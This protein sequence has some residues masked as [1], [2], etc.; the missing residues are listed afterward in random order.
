M[1]SKRQEA[2][3]RKTAHGPREA[4]R[5]VVHDLESL[6]GRSKQ[7]LLE[8]A[9]GLNIKGVSKLA[10]AELAKRVHAAQSAEPEAE[11]AR[12]A[13]A[14]RAAP[15]P[16]AKA[17]APARAPAPAAKGPAEKP[18]S[19]KAPVE[20][21]P[22]KAPPAKAP[23]AKASP[24]PAASAPPRGAV[25]PQP[26]PVPAPPAMDEVP[27]A[28]ARAVTPEP[29]P[30]GAVPTERPSPAAA[31]R[32][33]LGVPSPARAREE[34]IPWSY[35]IDRVTAMPVDPDTLY[36]YWE[37]T[38]SAIDRA[39]AALGAAGEG[40]WLNLRVFDT[41]GIIFDGGNAHSWFDHGLGRS[42]RQW[43]FRIGK[44]SSSATVEI[45]M[46]APDG[47][48]ARIARSSRVD[49][50][51]V[52]PSAW[53]DPEWMTV[54]AGGETVHAGRGGP[55]RPGDGHAP[56]MGGGAERH[57][58]VPVWVLLE[59]GEGERRFRELF[60]EHWERIEWREG[61]GEGWYELQGRLEWQVGPMVSSWEEGPFH[62]PVQVDPPSRSTWEG[63]AVA[64]TQGGVTR[65]VYG[66]WQVMIRNLHGR[67]EHAVLGRWQIYR[68]WATNGG[69]E[70]VQRLAT[71]IGAG[72]PGGASERVA[73]SAFLWRV[74][75]EERLGGASEVWRLGASEVRLRG[76]SEILLAGASERRLMGASER[77]LMGASEWRLGGASERQLMG[78]SERARRGASEWRLGGASERHLGGASE[79]ALRGASEQR[80]GGGSEERLGGAPGFTG[81]PGPDDGDWNWPPA[82]DSSAP[83]RE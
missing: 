54:L 76:A 13:P 15:G 9:A 29:P 8:L 40:A 70:E 14:G 80:L 71:G 30:G 46:R 2:P 83:G 38:D 32:L 73:A 52:A 57:E 31:A 56:P 81:S 72:A 5:R 78:A 65:V 64:Y 20:K 7:A 59:P 39:R 16:S 36:V 47:G 12:R 82:D 21:A 62:Y 11:P 23:A 53:S 44:P 60:G 4:G 27:T 41:S 6:L 69:I 75:S 50:P 35:G 18:A 49:F 67:A 58:H 74:G 19:A 37:V 63:G 33:D 42:D 55:V 34:H 77:R 24:A 25:E 28:A 61:G 22:A 43:F 66:P 51:P 79:R 26:A 48:F 3:D 68:S 17:S 45:G 10:K 1:T